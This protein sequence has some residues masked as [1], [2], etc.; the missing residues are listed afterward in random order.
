MDPVTLIVAALGAGL[1]VVANAAVGEAAKDAY[2][3]L[4]SRIAEHFKGK[5][6]HEAAL[7]GFEKD[8][9]AGAP[10]LAAAIKESQADSDQQV[11]QGSRALLQQADPD[12]AIARKYSNVIQGSVQGLVQG[13]HNTVTMNFGQPPPKT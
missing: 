5:P 11:L 2:Q 4:K 1:S 6:E 13:D 7:A 9:E 8:P 10:A 12:G 3:S